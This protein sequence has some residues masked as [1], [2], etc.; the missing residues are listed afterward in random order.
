MYMIASHKKEVVYK[1][2][3]FPTGDWNNNIDNCPNNNIFIIEHK[4]YFSFMQINSIKKHI[5]PQ[6]NAPPSNPKS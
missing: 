6:K 5:I 1:E 2:K 3:T 4:L